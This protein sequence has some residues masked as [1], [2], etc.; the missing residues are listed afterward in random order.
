[1]NK[2]TPTSILS[3]QS[4]VCFGYVGN[5]AAMFPLQRL[6]F[7][8]TGVNTVQFSNHTGYESFDGDVMTPEHVSR[9][10]SGIK[11]RGVF[12]N[13][14]CVISG[15]QGSESLGKLILSAVQDIKKENPSALYCCDP[16]IGDVGVGTFVKPEVA[17]FIKESCVPA[18][19]IITPNL[20]ELGYL[21]DTPVA[22]MNSL[23]ALQ[24][25]CK[26]LHQLGPKLILVTSIFDS[27]LP[28]DAIQMLV[29]M[30]DNMFVVETPKLSMKWPAS[31]SGDA[32]TALFVAYFLQSRDPKLA[33]EKTA[34]SIFEVFKATV[35]AETRELQFISAQEAMVSPL[36]YFT[37]KLVKSD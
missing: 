4:Y 33:L 35:E 14:S 26:K 5:K 28:S 32:T 16:V 24:S 27:A 25:A 20:Y 11:K 21:T 3:I 30:D 29:S 34:S 12:K 6:G 10:L 19:D 18:A 36:H 7:D 8:V 31:G 1:M 22:S 9:V 15:Y 17:R 37:A 2:F 23:F 13:F